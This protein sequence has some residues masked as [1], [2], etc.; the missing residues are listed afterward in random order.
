M[1]APLTPPHPRHHLTS[2]AACQC[3]SEH[4]HA[5]TQARTRS[6]EP[7]K[8]PPGTL[9]LP[10]HGQGSQAASSRCRGGAHQGQGLADH[11]TRAAVGSAEGRGA[12]SPAGLAQAPPRLPLALPTCPEPPPHTVAINPGTP[13][14]QPLCAAAPSGAKIS[15]CPW[16]ISSVRP[17]PS[18]GWWAGGTR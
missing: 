5:H 16:W 10:P 14:T 4:A 17:A 3:C 6:P 15:R 9:A 1:D 12:P 7:P 2:H 11:V 13:Q 8:P 18:R